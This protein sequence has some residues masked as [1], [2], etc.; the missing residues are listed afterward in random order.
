VTASR[1]GITSDVHVSLSGGIDGS[2]N[3]YCIANSD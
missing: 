2:D 3:I 1:A